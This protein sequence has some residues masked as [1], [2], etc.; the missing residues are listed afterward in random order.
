MKKLLLIALLA[1]L[2]LIVNAQDKY[3]VYK[4]EYS[5]YN[6][7]TEDWDVIRTNYPKEMTI[8]IYSNRIYIDAQNSLNIKIHS[9]GDKDYEPTYVTIKSEGYETNMGVNCTV[10]ATKYKSNNKFIINIF[11]Y[12][13]NG[14]HSSLS[15]DL[16]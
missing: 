5:R 4:A 1:I 16:N 6:D 12:D 7:I 2:S 13:S 11:F 15:Y 8:T 14:T 3:K 10:Y 9:V